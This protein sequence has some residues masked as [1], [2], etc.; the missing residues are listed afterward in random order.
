MHETFLPRER[1][2]A[3]LRRRRRELRDDLLMTF[4]DLILCQWV[5]GLSEIKVLACLF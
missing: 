1:G 5:M 2:G 3:L 4:N